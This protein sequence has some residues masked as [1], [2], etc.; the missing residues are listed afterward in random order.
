MDWRPDVAF[1]EFRDDSGAVIPYGERWDMSPPA[2]SYSRTDH[3]ERFEVAWT[4]ARALVD[5]LVAEYD[6]EVIADVDPAQDRAFPERAPRPREPIAGAPPAVRRLV[7]RGPGAPL[8][9]IETGS[10]GVVM[11]AGATLETSAPMC[12]CDACDERV[13]EMADWLESLAIAVATGMAWE[14]VERRGL[15]Y[16][17]TGRDGTDRSWVRHSRHERR[18][19]RAAIKAAPA[20]APWPTRASAD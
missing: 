7:P 17:M 2:D 11:L 16:G 9:V 6:V 1:A 19:A 18:A 20:F 15:A 4:L 10:P 14:R 13:E 12:S 8:T 5:H 3:L